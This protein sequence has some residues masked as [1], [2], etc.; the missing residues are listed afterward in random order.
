MALR[1]MTNAIK[2]RCTAF[3]ISDFIDPDD[4][5]K[6]LQIANRKHDVVAIQVYDQLSTELLPVGLMKVRDPETGEERWINTSSRR[7][8]ENYQNWWKSLQSNMHYAFRQSGVDSISVSTESDYVKAL[9][10]LFQQ[11]K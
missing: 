3:L 2:K 11:R 6:A 5:K 7:V 10:Q 1:Y 4:Y 9:L 8:R